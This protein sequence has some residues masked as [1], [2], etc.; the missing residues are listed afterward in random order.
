M[1]LRAHFAVGRG[2][3]LKTPCDKFLLEKLSISQLVLKFPKF[4]ATKHS[5]QPL[6]HRA[7][8]AFLSHTNYVLSLVS[9]FFNILFNTVFSS[10]P[11][12][13]KWSQ[14]FRFPYQHLLCVDVL[15]NI[16]TFTMM[17]IIAKIFV[18]KLS[19]SET[20]VL[21]LRYSY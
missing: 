6:Q 14:S 5:S 13:S 19:S 9:Y 20:F 10:T 17:A 15:S 4:C 21:P 2:I 16:G 8:S 12:F 7:T 1:D 18:N 11:K 3:I